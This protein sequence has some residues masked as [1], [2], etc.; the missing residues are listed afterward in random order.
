MLTS[1][2]AE[3]SE[4]VMVVDPADDQGVV[5]Q[6]DSKMEKLRVATSAPTDKA[7]N[8]LLEPR[9]QPCDACSFDTLPTELI[10]KIIKF[11]V[12]FAGRRSCEENPNKYYDKLHI[13]A[14][15]S[16]IFASI[17]KE[18]PELWSVLD[19]YDKPTNWQM[20]IRLSQ[21]YPLT[22]IHRLTS[23]VNYSRW[24][25]VLQVIPR[26]KVVSF[27]MYKPSNLETIEAPH[28]ETLTLGSYSEVAVTDLFRGGAPRVRELSLRSIA[29]R[30][31]TSPLMHQLHSLSLSTIGDHETPFWRIL[32]EALRECPDLKS[33]GL[34]R[35]W[36]TNLTEDAI[37]LDLP[38]LQTLSLEDIDDEAA[39]Y[40]LRNLRA[41]HITKFRMRDDPLL[42]MRQ[43][44]H[45]RTTTS[46]L[47]SPIDE[48]LSS[49]SSIRIEAGPRHV[50]IE[51]EAKFREVTTASF[52]IK[53]TFQTNEILD[54]F[55]PRFDMTLPISLNLY[56]GTNM[57]PIISSLSPLTRVASLVA[58]E[59]KWGGEDL[60][61]ILEALGAPRMSSG[62]HRTWLWPQL[63]TIKIHS[64]RGFMPECVLSML[65]RRHPTFM[66][67]GDE[68]LLQPPAPLKLLS[69][70]LK[71]S[72]HPDTLRGIE[73][74]AGEST[75]F[76]FFNL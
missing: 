10:L 13:L 62:D 36:Y 29:L 22:V 30:E 32:L 70:Y 8:E 42:P 19:T 31:W 37:V 45:F 65:R 39:D 11:V 21:S 40:L 52:A 24:S 59:P 27:T 66:S 55:V 56:V 26:C 20:S 46:F 49:A 15:V 12:D 7:A 75:D 47:A 74:V 68:E 69:L 2:N 5:S 1:V 25:A 18:T 72:I 4:T 50:Q 6:I 67:D 35:V 71:G 34:S 54:W 43:R 57:T 16:Y 28:L 14:Q 44:T 58:I 23:P 73:N 9:S 53:N 17:I 38:H 33:L 48:S 3:E 51:I 76:E 64:K 41:H 63:E 61:T 60:D